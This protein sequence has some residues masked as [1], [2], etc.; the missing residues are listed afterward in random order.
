[1]PPDTAPTAADLVISAGRVIDPV[2]G[3]DAPG[4]VSV[5]D[6]R[7]SGVGGL[8]DRPPPSGKRLDYPDGILLPGLVD[9]HA[10]PGL[11]DGRYGIDPDIHM[12]SRGSTT[13]L[14]Q[15]D[16]GARNWERYKEQVIGGRKTRIR[17]ALHLGRNGEVHPDGP[18]T[19]LEFADVAE[20]IAAIEGDESDAIWGITVNTSIMTCGPSDPHEILRRAI[21]AAEATGNPLLFGPR[22]APGWALEDQLP[23]LRAGDVF[24]YCSDPRETSLVRDGRIRD[25]AR[26]ARDRGIL[27]DLGHG[28]TSINFIAIEAMVAE[29]FLPDT[30]SSDVYSAH[31]NLQPIHDL[32]LVM[33]KVRAAGMTEAE[34]WPRVTIRPAEILGLENEIGTLNPGSCADLSVLRWDATPHVHTDHA[35]NDRS[36]GIYQPVVTIRGGE[37]FE[38]IG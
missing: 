7:I 16:A 22:R 26:E 30:I 21:E 2:T 23:L 34:I 35:G 25:C 4:W 13:V 28:T 32:P 18:F 6:G 3:S 24:T 19:E 1:M 14:S 12:L 15:G 27:Y 11:G 31:L 17:M 37:T 36:G 29:A 8:K 20:C 33:S 10:H 38:P 5:V 9:L